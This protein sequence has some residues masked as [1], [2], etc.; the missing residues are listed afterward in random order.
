MTSTR[1]VARRL[2]V[3]AWVLLATLL[4]SGCF[5]VKMDLAI[6]SDDTVDGSLVLAVDK[7]LAD[8]AG[9]EDAL[10][11]SLSGEGSPFTEKP[12]S[13]DVTQREYRD[14]D[15]IGVEYVLSGLPVT[16]FSAQQTGELEISRDGDRFV[17]SGNLDMTDQGAA[18]EGQADPT[19]LLGAPD[20]S[21]SITFPG[22]VV[23]ANGQVD[24]R[25]V[26]WQPTI[27]QPN[28]ISAVGMA[29]GGPS[30][31]LWIGVA[32]VVLLLALA[33]GA[34]VALRGRRAPAPLP[35][36]AA[37]ADTIL[38]AAAGASRPSAPRATQVIPVPEQ[39]TQ[40]VE[41]LPDEGEPTPGG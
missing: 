14:G 24:G 21:M 9:G 10:R 3:L 15:L 4:L 40:T 28:P 18:V 13:G 16:E 38:P 2:G 20:V 34:L 37:D 29:E 31:G 32:L 11:Q 36:P 6:Q 25:T 30:L 41:P 17:V 33:V 35:T 5:T 39:L 27:G 23:S 7:S 19:G 12:S 22:E 1:V 8:L 26:T